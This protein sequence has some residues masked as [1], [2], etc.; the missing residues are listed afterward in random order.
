MAVLI[1]GLVFVIISI[2]LIIKTKRFNDGTTDM[3][4]MGTGILLLLLTIISIIIALVL[5]IV[6]LCLLI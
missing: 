4:E 3:G 6:G 2:L 1:I 5:V